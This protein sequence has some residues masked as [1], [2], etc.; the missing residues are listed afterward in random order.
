MKSFIDMPG[1]FDAMPA[2]VAVQLSHI[3]VSKGR[4]QLYE[5]QLP[6][7]LQALSQQSR[8]ES[9]RASNAIE[10]IEVGE[11][12][13]EKLADSDRV[14]PRNRSEK[15][16]AGYRDAVDEMMRADKLESPSVP[17]LLYLHRER[18]RRSGVLVVGPN[19]AFL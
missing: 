16:F 19:R 3:D 17:Y 7:L 1:A 18:L 6:E 9:I 14:R 13:A 10:G 2:D 4:E 15:E 12:R 11:D 5:N 8:V